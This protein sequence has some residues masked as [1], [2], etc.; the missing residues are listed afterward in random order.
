MKYIPLLL[1]LSLIGCMGGNFDIRDFV[2]HPIIMAIIIIAT[3][4]FAFKYN[5]K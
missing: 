3:L 2:R 4:Y 1:P 5:K